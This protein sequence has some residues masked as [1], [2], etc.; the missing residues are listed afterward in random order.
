MKQQISKNNISKCQ[1]VKAPEVP[2]FNVAELFN[3]SPELRLMH[4]DQEYRLRLT[5]SGK[6][7][8]TK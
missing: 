5:K 8:L 6:L 7:I 4:S 1:G 2:V 3:G